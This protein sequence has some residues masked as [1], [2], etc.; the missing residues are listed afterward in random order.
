MMFCL[1]TGG[2]TSGEQCLLSW[3][4][5]DSQLGKIV[6][7][8]WCRLT[9]RPIVFTKDAAPLIGNT[10]VEA[11]GFQLVGLKVPTHGTT[12]ML[13]GGGAQYERKSKTEE[14]RRKNASRFELYRNE[15]PEAAEK[16]GRQHSGTSAHKFAVACGK[17]GGKKGAASQ[18]L[19]FDAAV[20][21]ASTVIGMFRAA[22]TVGEHWKTATSDET[23]LDGGDLTSKQ[24]RSMFALQAKTDLFFYIEHGGR[25]TMLCS[26]SMAV[27]AFSLSKGEVS[28]AFDDAFETEGWTSTSG[29]CRFSVIFGDETEPDSEEIDPMTGDTVDALS[30][31][32][33]YGLFAHISGFVY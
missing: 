31:A 4:I 32:D 26:P 21:V 30:D 11:F 2:T 5:D 23:P 12:Q 7:A 1:N 27:P 18:K 10:T 25:H 28:A 22:R 16:I 3:N 24:V 8:M 9:D 15:N 20:A 17:K 19:V 33:P 13:R 14:A 6:D 29:D